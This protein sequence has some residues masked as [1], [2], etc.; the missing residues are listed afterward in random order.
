[1]A[2]ERQRES[3]E[4]LIMLQ[5]MVPTLAI[6][7]PRHCRWRCEVMDFTGKSVMP[8]LVMVHEHFYYPTRPEI[9]RAIGREL[10]PL[11]CRR[12]RGLRREFERLHGP[13]PR[14]R[15][16]TG[17]KPGPAIDATRHMWMML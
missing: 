5:Q 17:E 16:S 9:M 11:S 10:P 13:Q 6:P 4:A 2:P 1:M 3:N 12:R 7:L 15:Q 8:G 14:S